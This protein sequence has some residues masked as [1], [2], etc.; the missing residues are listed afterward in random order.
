MLTTSED[1]SGF[2]INLKVHVLE[3]KQLVEILFQ[4]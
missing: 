4:T 3:S 1:L 2:N